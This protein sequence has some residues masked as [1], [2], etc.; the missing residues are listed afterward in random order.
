MGLILL[1]INKLLV[2]VSA[3]LPSS[4]HK[5]VITW[6]SIIVINNIPV[7]DPI[8]KCF[9]DLLLLM[10][11]SFIYGNKCIGRSNVL[12]RYTCVFAELEKM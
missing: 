8:T 3:C 1:K 6:L 12:I 10:F 9:I 4:G 5:L 2:N 7:D 11:K